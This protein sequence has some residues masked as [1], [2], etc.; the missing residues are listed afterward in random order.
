MRP[1]IPMTVGPM[2]VSLILSMAVPTL[3][4]AQAQPKATPSSETHSVS[5]SDQGV[6]RAIDLAAK[7]RCQEAL[8]ALKLALSR[9]SAKQA[10]DKQLEYR[11]SMA[12]AKCAMSLNQAQ[13]AVNA[14][15]ILKAASLTAPK[16][17]TLPTP[18]FSSWP[19][20]RPQDPAEEAQLSTKPR[21]CQP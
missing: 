21:N 4:Y 1:L 15:F 17:W 19:F 9:S 16:A 8:P 11:T 14:L 12:A 5:S 6:E 7:G 18:I 10:A 13:T 20:R 2:T 3:C